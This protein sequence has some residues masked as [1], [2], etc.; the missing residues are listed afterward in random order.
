MYVAHA[1]I[2]LPS[3]TLLDR[4]SGIN[5]KKRQKSD[6][7]VLSDL[8]PDMR[9]CISYLLYYDDVTD[10]TFRLLV[11]QTRPFGVQV[12]VCPRRTLFHHLEE[13][14]VMG[15]FMGPGDGP[16][17][18]RVY[19]TKGTGATVRQYRHVVTPLVCLEMHAA[20]MYCAGANAD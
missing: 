15:H 8:A 1:Q 5:C 2:L 12:I 20:L 3:Q 14:G 17:M 9:R 6:V 13:R 11:Q 16:S 10:D 4:E 18:D 19:I 7:D